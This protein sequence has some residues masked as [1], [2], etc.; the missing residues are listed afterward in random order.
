MNGFLPPNWNLLM[1]TRNP[2]ALGRANISLLVMVL[3]L[4]SWNLTSALNKSF[5]KAF[6]LQ[7]FS[8]FIFYFCCKI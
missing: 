1:S 3:D 2:R 6:Q 5:M 8:S 4:Y 7:I